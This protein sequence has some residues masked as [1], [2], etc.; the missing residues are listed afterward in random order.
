MHAGSL[1]AEVLPQSGSPSLRRLR[2][3][4]VNPADQELADL[5]QIE[6][7]GNRTVSY[8]LA[9]RLMDVVGAIILLVL[10]FPVMA[11]TCLLLMWTTRGRPI[12]V[13]KRVGFLGK[14]FPM[15]KF[16]TMIIGAAAQQR[17]I[18]NHHKDGPIFKNFC[19]PRITR[20]GRVLRSLSI[21]E[22][23]QLINVLLGH[24]SLVGP[25]PALGDE[26]R[27]YKPWQRRR[28]AVKPGL[29][30]L[31]QVSGRSEIGFEKWMRM[32]IWY[33]RHQ[34]LWTDLKLLACTPWCVIT[35]RGAY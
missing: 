28:L 20:L 33:L 31:W 21:D 26:V 30:C 24:M 22:T 14:P 35:R 34:S 23:P 5:W 12:F 17:A 6:P 25:R 10:L 29:T 27:Q 8:V 16:R 2:S 1:L 18:E 13:Q 3:A 19:D 9:K 32:D 4:G 7:A 15:Y 11:C